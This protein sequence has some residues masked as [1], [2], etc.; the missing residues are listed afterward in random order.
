ME[1]ETTVSNNHHAEIKSFQLKIL[2][3]GAWSG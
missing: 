1:A 3:K 2:K